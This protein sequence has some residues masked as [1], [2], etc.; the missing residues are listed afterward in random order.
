MAWQIFFNIGLLLLRWH[1]IDWINLDFATFILSIKM[2]NFDL[3]LFLPIK[4]NAF[5]NV[6]CCM[7][8]ILFRTQGVNFNLSRI[9]S[10]YRPGTWTEIPYQDQIWPIKRIVLAIAYFSVAKT[11]WSFVSCPQFRKKYNWNE[12]YGLM[13]LC[14]I[15]VQEEFWRDIVPIDRLLILTTGSI[16]L[17]QDVLAKH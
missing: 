7:L 6:V 9:E 16:R 12:C 5:K 8:A 1:A 4:D 13:R 2:R 14:E 17:W 10:R 15:W 3:K 11:F